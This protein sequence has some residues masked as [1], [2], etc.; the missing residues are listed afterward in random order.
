MVSASDACQ[1]TWPP[2]KVCPATMDGAH[3]TP[4]HRT[5]ARS[6]SVFTGGRSYGD[7]STPSRHCVETSKKVLTNFVSRPRQPLIRFSN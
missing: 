2:L 1:A 5:T 6:A 7:M 3:I 4:M